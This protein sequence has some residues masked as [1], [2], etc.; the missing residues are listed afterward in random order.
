MQPISGAT[1]FQCQLSDVKGMVA[2]SYDKGLE[3]QGVMLWASQ[4][5][6][7]GELSRR[8]RWLKICR[9]PICVSEFLLL[10]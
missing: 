1:H 10:F 9:G 7:L 3:V 6:T 2:G 8:A 4:H 5:G